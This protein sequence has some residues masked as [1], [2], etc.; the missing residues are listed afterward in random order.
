MSH[1]SSFIKETKQLQ[2]K[3]NQIPNKMSFFT[4]DETD[5]LF[6]CFYIFKNGLSNY[7]MLINRNI[8]V[9]KEEKIKYIEKIRKEKQL[10]KTNK[11]KKINEIEN[12]LLN[13]TCIDLKTFYVLCL[14][15]N[16]HFLLIDNKTYFE[17]NVNT[18]HIYIIHKKK[19]VYTYEIEIVS[20]KIEKYKTSLLLKTDIDKTFKAISNYTLKE[21]KDI[22]SKISFPIEK[23]WKKE[24]IYKHL[25]NNLP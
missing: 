9:E 13:D 18:S 25:T 15:E 5:T 4:P 19:N 3:D 7:E 16:I 8:V 2:V 24:E 17:N 1:F 21:L 20:D 11:I 12:N 22:C 14:L 6:W 10:L 23:E